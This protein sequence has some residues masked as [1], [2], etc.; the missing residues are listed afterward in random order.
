MRLSMRSLVSRR[1]YDAVGT[2]NYA[3]SW[4][5]TGKRDSNR[6]RDWGDALISAR[7][8]DSFLE[9]LARIRMRYSTSSRSRHS[10][11]STCPPG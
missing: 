2:A 6:T 8:K 7:F 4:L 3:M 10:S 9:M 1:R 11:T 5:H